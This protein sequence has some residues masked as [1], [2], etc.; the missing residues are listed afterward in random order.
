[1][2]EDEE[3]QLGAYLTQLATSLN[4]IKSRASRKEQSIGLKKVAA[5]VA[6]RRGEELSLGLQSQQARGRDFKRAGEQYAEAT[7]E[8]QHYLSFLLSKKADLQQEILSIKRKIN[9]QEEADG[10]L[11]KQLDLLEWE[12]ARQDIGLAKLRERRRGIAARHCEEVNTLTTMQASI[13]ADRHSRVEAALAHQARSEHIREVERSGEVDDCQQTSQ[14]RKVHL[15][16]LLFSQ[17]FSS[18]MRNEQL[19]EQ[20]YE[21]HFAKLKQNTS[22]LNPADLLHRFFSIDESY[23]QL[24]ERVALMQARIVALLTQAGEKRAQLEALERRK[25]LSLLGIGLPG[26]PC[27][28]EVR[29][30]RDCPDQPA[31]VALGRIHAWTQQ[32]QAKLGLEDQGTLAQQLQTLL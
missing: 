22:I 27:Q 8:A 18:K 32:Q 23:S 19:R 5:K 25:E 4:Q 31:F 20:A 26:P 15:A 2:R 28:D 1:M 3:Q 13:S 6:R 21:L 10:Q 11:G 24:Q 16:H 30:V 7:A 29:A 9:G 17:M 12:G 14:F